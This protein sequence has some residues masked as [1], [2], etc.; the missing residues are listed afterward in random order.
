M[1]ESVAQ[2][3]VNRREYSSAVQM[4]V[5]LTVGALA[6]F[7]RHELPLTPQQLPT[8]T[9]V[10][11]LAVVTAALGT[12]AGV[13]TAVVGG[14][15]SWFFFFNSERWYPSM[16]G[17]VQLLGF[18]V[19]ALV[20]VTSTSFFRSSERQRHRR[21]MEVL[22]REA[23]SAD[24]FAREMAHRLKNALAIVQSLAFQTF[25]HSSTAA[26]AFAGRLRTVAEANELLSEHIS[27]PT[28]D[29]R[30]VVHNALRLFD[31]QQLTV[32]NDCETCT[33]ADQQVIS[34][35]MAI[36]ELGT[37]AIKYGAWSNAVGKVSVQITE[38]VNEL[39]F[40][41]SESGGPALSAAT[42]TGF[43]TRLLQRAGR[44]VVLQYKPEGLFYSVALT[45][46]A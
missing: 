28:A 41:W 9:T 11:A 38:N 45:R 6:V 3:L 27:R 17:W 23:E 20:I 22:A 5:G 25:G 36:H 46:A 10:I 21:E 40:S 8:I 31:R 15:L 2:R 29:V 43:G 26:E 12:L 30:E 19:I 13:T 14:G 35:A 4:L 33:I 7:I 42:S 32:S 39:R 16:S 44:D 37:N 18:S 24:L 34:L 1:P